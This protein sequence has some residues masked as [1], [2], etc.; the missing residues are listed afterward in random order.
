[1]TELCKALVPVGS[2]SYMARNSSRRC[3]NPAGD[4]GYCHLHQRYAVP[5]S[6]P[7]MIA[8]LRKGLSTSRE[9][10]VELPA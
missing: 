3:G 9:G 5:A 7:G 2:F 6:D 1:M 10:E 8:D 4:N